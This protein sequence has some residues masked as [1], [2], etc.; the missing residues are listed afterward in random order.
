MNRGVSKALVTGGA[1]FIGSHI[2]DELIG[3]GVETIVID[4]FSTGFIENLAQHTGSP[5]L[6]VIKGDVFEVE[7]LLKG[8]ADIDVVFHEAAIASVP[9]SVAEPLLVHRVNVDG[10]LHMLNYCVE[11]HIRR[12]VFA[13][14][15]SVYG[16]LKDFPAS[17]DQLCFPSSP[18]GSSKLS[19]E[20]YLS[21]FY[22]TYGLETVGLRY[23]N[24]YGPRQRMSDYSGVITVFINNLLKGITP[25]IFGDGT[26]TRDFV[27]VKD[28]VRANMLA[29]ETASATGECFNVASGTSTSILDL[30]DVLED[31][32]GVRLAPH[33]MPTRAG[34]VK[35]GE[36]S[37][38]KI[39]RVLGYR[40]STPIAEGLAQVVDAIKAE[41]VTPVAHN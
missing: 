15:A 38:S 31:I 28:I 8:V 20:T 25:T 26:Q 11:K 10:S 21:S 19:V 1:G 18:Y 16:V 29:M 9:R 39:E 41:A 7:E 14:S 34:D 35:S 17:E 36:G 40:S 33:F 13:S 32:T 2:V 30:L 5:L 24:V 27:F 22:R 23:F 12:L 3:R 4:N 37:I 6:R